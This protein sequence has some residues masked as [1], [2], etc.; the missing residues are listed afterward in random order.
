MEVG[1][2]KHFYPD[3]EMLIKIVLSYQVSTKCLEMTFPVRG[4]GP[5]VLFLAFS[6]LLN[7]KNINQWKKCS[8]SVNLTHEF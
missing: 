5:A 6:H 4:N 7:R 1:S 2:N 3:W 8:L